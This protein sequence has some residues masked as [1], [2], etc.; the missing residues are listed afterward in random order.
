[1]SEICHGCIAITPDGVSVLHAATAAAAAR[2]SLV[3]GFHLHYA[4]SVLSLVYA[5]PFCSTASVELKSR[6]L[7]VADMSGSNAACV[8]R[9]CG[10]LCCPSAEW[11]MHAAYCNALYETS[12]V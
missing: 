5:V 7:P 1:M 11:R 6:S 2:Q 4:P 9:D 12:L 3:R 8:I 10:G